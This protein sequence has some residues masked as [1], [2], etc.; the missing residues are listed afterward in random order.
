MYEQNKPEGAW[1]NA[2]LTFGKD[3]KYDIKFNYDSK[4][5]D[6]D[7]ENYQYEFEKNPRAKEFTPE[8]WRKALCKNAKYLK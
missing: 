1:L 7:P 3:K 6:F 4:P 5:E 2:Y 8:W